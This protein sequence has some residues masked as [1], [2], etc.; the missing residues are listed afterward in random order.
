M[1]AVSYPFDTTGTAPSN[2][3]KDELHTLTEVNSAPYRI[4]IPNCAPFY[5]ENLVLEHVDQLGVA[6]EMQEGV[7]FYFV[8]PYVAAFRSVGRPVYGGMAMLSDLPQGTMRIKTYQTVGGPWI[9]DR[10]YVYEQLLS[11]QYNK[12]TTYWD[13]I[14]NVQELF[15][16]TEHQQSIGDVEG[17]KDLLAALGTITQALLAAPNSIPPAFMAHLA[18][19]GNVHELSKTDLGLGNVANLP[20]ATDMEVM[21]REPVDK[22]VTLKQILMLLP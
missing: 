14:T 10:F 8:L 2:L 16:P 22:Y 9:A 21:N 12:R 7:D 6:R 5:L 13:L 19:K 4:L 11:S 1:T 3:V 18:S 20:M 17:H 15:P